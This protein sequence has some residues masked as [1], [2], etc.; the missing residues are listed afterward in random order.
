MFNEI[1][2]YADTGR[3]LSVNN[4]IAPCLD[5]I[6]TDSLVDECF[7]QLLKQL[8]GTV[9][10]PE[11][12][13]F[14][15]MWLLVGC[16][17]H[18]A[19]EELNLL[20][21]RILS[22]RAQLDK[23]CL[24]S[25]CL[26]RLDRARDKLPRRTSPC[27]VEVDAIQKGTTKI[28]HKI[29]YPD[30]FEG[31]I[32][33]ESDS[34]SE[35]ICM[36][37][38]QKRVPLNEHDRDQLTSS[39]HL[40]VKI[41]GRENEQESSCIIGQ[42]EYFF[43]FVRSLLYLL[44]RKQR[45]VKGSMRAITND[46]STVDYILLVER[47]LWVNVVPGQNWHLDAICHFPQELKNFL[48]GY[49]QHLNAH[50]ENELAEIAFQIVL[51]SNVALFKT[52]KD[53]LKVRK[54]KSKSIEHYIQCLHS[55][56]VSRRDKDINLR[57]KFLL[58]LK[59][60]S[61]FTFGAT[62]FP[63]ECEDNDFLDMMAINGKG[64]VLYR[65]MNSNEAQIDRI[66]PMDHVYS[67]TAAQEDI[68]RPNILISLRYNQQRNTLILYTKDA[69]RIDEILSAYVNTICRETVQPID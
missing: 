42:C 11:H 69:Y 40:V 13:Y 47:R 51:Q 25:D 41:N 1:N 19:D 65:T 22:D 39:F 12:R 2:R 49:H 66:V 31:A 27:F 63:I 61:P 15:L 37:A 56:S 16:C 68:S 28:F 46:T 7:C 36:N 62:F 6:E 48:N 57:T 26:L 18:P 17:V 4:I 23:K 35:E 59:Q 3:I 24:A 44:D 34:T 21:K 45:Q 50:T 29:N 43:D 67:W 60:A 33:V 52:V 20:L 58:C 10:K 14:E 53:V 8:N 32:S 5:N 30:G 55:H 38:I 9:C 64:I 54:S